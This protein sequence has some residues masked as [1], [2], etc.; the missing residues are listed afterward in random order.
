MIELDK[1]IADSL[2]GALKNSEAVELPY[3]VIYIWTVSGRAEL[4]SV[5]EVQYFGGWATKAEEADTYC[6][7]TGLSIPATW[8]RET[9]TTKEGESF[10]AYVTRSV[11]VAPFAQRFSWIVNGQ[12]Q[13]KYEDKARGHNQIIC[14]LAERTKQGNNVVYQPWGPVVLSAKGNQG[15]ALKDSFDRWQKAL[16]PTIYKVAPGVPA[17]CFYAAVGTFGKERS[18]V[19]VGKK[20]AQSPITPVSAY[21]PEGEISEALLTSLF[22]GNDV[23]AL[24]D[25]Y[26]KQSAEW[27]AAWKNVEKMPGN[28]N[29]AVDEVGFTVGDGVAPEDELPY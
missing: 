7:M 9:I 8:K 20:G 17:W 16:A 28:G 25:D 11:I 21:I 24:M 5:S 29:G 19:N 13:P 10:E 12:H 4:K 6:A 3:P 23:A 1:K 14:Y 26:R 2:S 15:K 22:V 18:A 27:I